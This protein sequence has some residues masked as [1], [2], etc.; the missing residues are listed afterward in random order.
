MAEP[1]AGF[2]DFWGMGLRFADLTH[3]RML[4]LGLIVKA[5]RRKNHCQPKAS[6]GS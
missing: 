2:Y 1:F 4:Q 5:I 6:W 3:E